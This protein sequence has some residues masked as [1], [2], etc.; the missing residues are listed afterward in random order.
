MASICLR[1]ADG[2]DCGVDDLL[3]PLAVGAV[4]VQLAAVAAA[5]KAWQV[6]RVPEAA[7][8][9]WLP[10]ATGDSGPLQAGHRVH[11]ASGGLNRSS[12]SRSCSS[13][14]APRT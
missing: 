12:T 4:P 1:G 13:G 8:G 14:R 2:A 11:G 7:R 3:E 5:E 9:L 6:R 10:L